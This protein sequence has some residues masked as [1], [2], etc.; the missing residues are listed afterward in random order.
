MVLKGKLELYEKDDI[1][2]YTKLVRTSPNLY[3]DDG[4]ELAL[5]FLFGIQSWWNPLPQASYGSGNIGWDTNRYIGIGLCMFNNSSAERAA[6]LNAIA[7]GT[8]CSYT[9]AETY[10]VDPEDSYLSREVTTTRVVSV[11]TRRDQSVEIKGFINVPGNIPNPTV[12]REFAMFLGA[13]GP[14]HDPSYIESSRPDS[15]I[16]R[17]SLYGT[18][19]YHTSGGACVPCDPTDS[20]AELCYFDDPYNATDDV[21]FR[22]VFGEL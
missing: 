20:G 16:C 21:Q 3:V 1:G 9:V 11:C 2:E 5:D 12:I 4:K 13:T 17:S 7:T 10:L 19:W 6:G 18:G 22:W 8:E 15:M 14:L